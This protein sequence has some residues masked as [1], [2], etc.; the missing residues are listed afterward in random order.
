MATRITWTKRENIAYITIIEEINNRPCTLDWNSLSMLENVIDEIGKDSE[1][2]AAVLQSGSEK[3]FVVGANINTLETLKADNIMYWVK[4]GHRVFNKIQQLP[5]PVI[6]KVESYA[7]GGGLELAMA[8]DMIIATENA[9]FAQPE[10]SLGVMPGWGGSY[11]LAKLIGQNRAKEMFF[12]GHQITAQQAY[13]WGIVNHVCKKEEIDAKINEVLDAI[14]NN[15]EKV[16]QFVKE[17]INTHNQKD[18]SVN[19]YEEANTS[20]VCMS[21]ESTLTRLQEFFKNR[22]KK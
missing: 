13:E 15:E 17:I 12:T 14:L 11:R 4:N 10:A 6:A 21:S 8:C 2:R 20:Y 1:V 22:R 7:L 19:A 3:S 9:K 16:L 18:V 5:I